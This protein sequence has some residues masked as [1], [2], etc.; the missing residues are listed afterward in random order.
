MNSLATTTVGKTWS[1]SKVKFEGL[2]LLHC[3]S[4]I[5]ECPN[6]N[7]FSHS[8]V[9]HN[10]HDFCRIIMIIFKYLRILPRSVN[11][12]STGHMLL[13]S[14]AEATMVLIHWS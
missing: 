10:L 11:L 9:D 14:T 7:A 6:N 3:I 4:A 2:F 1:W 13:V 8:S 12:A 5:M